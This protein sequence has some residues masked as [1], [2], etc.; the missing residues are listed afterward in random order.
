MNEPLSL[1][2]ALLTGVLLG[3]IFFGGLWWTIRQ[4]V[5][6]QWV[7]LWFL[8]SF[9]LRMCIVLLGLYFV[10]GSDWQRLLACL[11]GF[12]VARLVVTRLTRGV[13]QPNPLA[14]EASHAP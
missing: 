2:P 9:L 8:G 5:S 7:G 14:Q 11:L 10:S 3:A 4:G 6:S 13:E 12:I 1:V